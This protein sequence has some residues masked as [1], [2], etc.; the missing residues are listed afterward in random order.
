M[1][2]AGTV[3]IQ[4]V[5]M[6]NKK[7]LLTNFLFD[8]DLFDLEGFSRNSLKK[9][10]PKIAPMAIWVELTGNPN[11]VAIK[12][13][14]ADDNATQ[15][16]L[17]A[18]NLVIF[19]PT[20]FINLGPNNNKPS[21]IPIAPIVITQSGIE[22]LEATLP[23]SDNVLTIAAI[24]PTAFATS[25]APC[26]KKRRATQIIKVNEK[27]YKYLLFYFLKNLLY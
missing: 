22:T 5:A 21:A 4:A 23:P 20:V 11:V 10:I 1:A 14:I 9:P 26:A 18:F 13:V 25:F 19:C 27:V 16:A 17:G 3:T 2:D 7:F 15:Y 6:E 24:G 8:L 12:T